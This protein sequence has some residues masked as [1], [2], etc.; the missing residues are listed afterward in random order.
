MEPD[1][2]RM[3]L[4]RVTPTRSIYVV[5]QK[6]AAAG[7]QVKAQRQQKIPK[8]ISLPKPGLEE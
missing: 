8:D 6:E 4:H 1:F 2:T 5:Q 3:N 7:Q